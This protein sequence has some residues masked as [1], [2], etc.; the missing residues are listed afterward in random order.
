MTR[1]ASTADFT[2]SLEEKLVRIG[3]NIVGKVSRV[4]FFDAGSVAYY[5]PA[6]RYQK[7]RKHMGALERSLRPYGLKPL[8][9]PG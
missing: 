9:R 3:S 5:V 6:I 8:I 4:E 1:R 7:A 2:M